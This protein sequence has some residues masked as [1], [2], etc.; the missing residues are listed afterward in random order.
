MNQEKK[1]LAVAFLDP[2]V[3]QLNLS[4]LVLLKQYFNQMKITIEY[5]YEGHYCLIVNIHFYRVIFT[6]F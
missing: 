6:N 3:S 5:L 1:S 4:T 2:K